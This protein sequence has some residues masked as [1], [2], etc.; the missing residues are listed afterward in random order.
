M[1]IK[2]NFLKAWT[3]SFVALYCLFC[4]PGC[5]QEYDYAK[6]I[7]ELDSL[8]VVTEQAIDYFMMVDSTTCY[9]AYQKEKDY[10]LF[11]EAHVGD[12]VARETAE[13]MATFFSTEKALGDYL[14]MRPVWLS[15][16]QSVVGQVA[17]L[18]ADLK[19]GS[20]GSSEAVEFI[21]SEKKHT[22]KI[23]EELKMNTQLVRKH[24]DVYAKNLPVVEQVLKLHNAGILP[25]HNPPSLKES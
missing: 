15:E 8:K 20:I 19:N 4:L 24:L 1:V 7:K 21:G 10:R 3:F 13:A 25:A 14:R 18:S 2:P 5:R 23:I 6:H 16:A 9:E 17:R 22:E 12:T 11:I